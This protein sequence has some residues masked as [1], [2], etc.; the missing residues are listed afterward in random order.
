SRQVQGRWVRDAQ[1]HHGFPFPQ[2]GV[3][4]RSRRR[5]R[6]T[7][8]VALKRTV[9][10]GGRGVALL[11]RRWLRRAHASRRPTA[12]RVGG[13][14]PCV[15]EAL[16]RLCPPYLVP[17]ERLRQLPRGGE[18][19]REQG[20]GLGVNAR[21]VPFQYDVEVRGAFAPGLAAAPA[22]ALEIV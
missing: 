11:A 15:R 6:R 17:A 7:V 14:A 20:D 16:G 10:K 8:A 3:P 12:G 19:L 13:R 22:L 5:H 1:R 4:R 2:A 9:G 18:S 21:L